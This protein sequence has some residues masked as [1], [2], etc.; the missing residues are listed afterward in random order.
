VHASGASDGGGGGDAGFASDA[1]DNPYDLDGDGIQVPIDC[2]DADPANFPGNVEVADGRDNDC[3]GYADDGLPGVDADGDGFVG[4]EDC[5]DANPAIF[6][7]A[8]ETANAQDD[9]CDGMIDEGG[10]SM[11]VPCD[12][13]GAVT[14]P[15]VSLGMCDGL[16]SETAAGPADGREIMSSWTVPFSPTEGCTMLQ[17][18]SG[19]T[20]GNQPGTYQTD[21]GCDF[22]S[23]GGCATIPPTFDGPANDE[24]SVTLTFTV[25]E[26]ANTLSWDFAFFSVEWPEWVGQGYNDTFEAE[27]Q[28]MMFTGN[29]S[30]DE[31]GASITVDNVLFDT[32]CASAATCDPDLA[33]TGFDDTTNGGGTTHWLQTATPVVPGETIT[34]TFR[35][36]DSGDGILDSAVV[37]DNLVFNDGVIEGG[38]GTTPIQ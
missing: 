1:G 27:I 22:I 19:L 36:Y 10:T 25:P 13:G 26:G 17:L 29:A 18:S 11:H 4:P 6:P 32:T 15:A 33:G 37:V 34:L 5:N 23:G 12:C 16:L 35:I 8:P 20:P 28:S 38:P 31:T 7:G 30:F 9:D 21:P 24:L 2:D 3:D 14:S